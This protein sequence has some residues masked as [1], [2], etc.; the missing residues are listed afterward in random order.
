[1]LPQVVV[2]RHR[3]RSGRQE[4]P[5]LLRRREDVDVGRQPTRVVERAD[6]DEADRIAGAGIV[7]PHGDA[8]ARAARDALAG[9][10]RRRRLDE[11]GLAAQQLDAVRLD[12]RV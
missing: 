6:A 5:W 12:Q 4:D 10:A 11:L 2:L 7:A 9:A 8:A 3:W 1:M